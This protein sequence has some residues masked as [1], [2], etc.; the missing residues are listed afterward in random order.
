M[1]AGIFGIVAVVGTGW[2]YTDRNLN[3]VEIPA[4]IDA[5]K[6]TCKLEMTK[7]YVVARRTLSTDYLDCDEAARMQA[8]DSRMVGAEVL[9]R[10]EVDVRYVSPADRQVHT[11]S[12]RFGGGNAAKLAR[13]QVGG[14]V[15]IMANTSKP[16]M[17]EER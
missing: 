4:R 1:R 13:L 3:Y 15:P 17:I 14:V 7:Y 6:T 5:V 8:E 12:Y 10:T 2:Y 9:R 11:A 16:T